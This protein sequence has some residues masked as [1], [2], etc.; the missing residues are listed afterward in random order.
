MHMEHAT[1][2]QPVS[3]AQKSSRR[4]NLKKTRDRILTLE[5][6]VEIRIKDG[7]TTTELFPP[8]EELIQ[9]GRTVDPRPELVYRRLHFPDGVPSEYYWTTKNE[10]LRRYGGLGIQRMLLDT[11]LEVIQREALRGD[12]HLGPS[13][14][15]NLAR[16][17]EHGEC[18][19]PVCTRN[20]DLSEQPR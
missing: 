3:T 20:Q 7:K 8:N 16:P 12:G 14:V 4:Q 9:L 13:G 1:T 6:W 19:C 2:E 10:N 11:W 17:K 5:Q 15:G 18:E